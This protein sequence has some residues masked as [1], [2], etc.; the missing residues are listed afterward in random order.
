[1]VHGVFPLLHITLKLY[2]TIFCGACG[3]FAVSIR[4][5]SSFSSFGTQQR[6]TLS[7]IKHLYNVTFY[8]VVLQVLQVYLLLLL[9]PAGLGAL[10]ESFPASILLH[11]YQ[12]YHH[13]P[14]GQ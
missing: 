9:S 2:L 7:H 3:L 5:N 6:E 11:L 1:M 14:I 8:T 12:S 4:V 13:H 10:Q